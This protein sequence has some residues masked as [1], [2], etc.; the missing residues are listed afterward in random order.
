[1]LRERQIEDNAQV[2]GSLLRA[3]HEGIQSSPLERGRGKRTSQSHFFVEILG[4]RG[5]VSGGGGVV[6]QLESR[7]LITHVRGGPAEFHEHDH[8]GVRVVVEEVLPHL[9]GK[10]DSHCDLGPEVV[11]QPMTGDLLV[12]GLVWEELVQD[13]SC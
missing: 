3:G 6:V 13:G 5:W 4:D 11:G 10:M 7:H 1:M 12:N 9:Q 2:F 8:L